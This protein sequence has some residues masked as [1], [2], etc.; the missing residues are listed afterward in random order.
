MPGLAES[1]Q[2]MS[3]SIS[4]LRADT[5][6]PNFPYERPRDSQALPVLKWAGG[7]GRLISDLVARLPTQFDRYFEAFFGGGAL[8]FWLQPL[9]AQISDINADLIQLYRCVRDHVE[10]LIE[11]L[12]RHPYEKNYYY[13]MRSLNPKTLAPVARA[14]RMIYLNRTCFNGLYRVNRRGQFNVP[15]GRYKNPVI[16]QEDRLRAVSSVLQDVD[17][18]H[19]CFRTALDAAKAG[20]FVYFDPP[21]LP[22]SRTANFTSYTSRSFTVDDQI[23][24]SALFAS[25]DARGVRCMLS[26]SDTPL[27]R[28]LYGDYQIDVV[29]APRAISRS[30]NGRGPVAELIVRNYST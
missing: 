1:R 15:F 14:G 16:C 5:Q 2:P 19:R 27:I 30:A 6:D 7:K 9:N 20:D 22:V 8:F 11:D 29:M 3:T 12:K 18:D 26:N 25:L 28:E 13:A 10:T 4:S 23:D 21:Y 24:L 17:I